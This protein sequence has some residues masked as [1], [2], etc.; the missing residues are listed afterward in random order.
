MLNGN[1]RV[2]NYSR[3]DNLGYYPFDDHFHANT[4]PKSVTLIDTVTVKLFCE[5]ERNCN[6][7]VA[8]LCIVVKAL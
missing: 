2:S 6:T 3:A 1:D 4:F 5:Q 7:L 8:T